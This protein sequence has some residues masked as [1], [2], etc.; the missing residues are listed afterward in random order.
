MV[1]KKKVNS[2]GKLLKKHSAVV[3]VSNRV[4]ALQR[5][6]YSGLLY[7][8]KPLLEQ[9]KNLIYFDADIKVLKTLISDKEINNKELKVA[10]RALMQTIVE[11]NVLKKDKDVWEAS[12]LLSSVKIENGRITYEI[13]A[14]IKQAI[15]EPRMYAVLD[16]TVIKQLTSKH[17]ISLYELAKDYVGA[18]IPSMDIETF[19]KLM[20]IEKDQYINFYDLKRRVID[21]ANAEINEN[22]DID[23]SYK[24]F[25]EG[26]KVTTIKFSV[27]EKSKIV[28][29]SNTEQNS[30]SPKP[31]QVIYKDVEFDHFAAT[32]SIYEKYI[33]KWTARDTKYYQEDQHKFEQISMEAIEAGILS[34]YLRKSD[35]KI[36]SFH[37][38]LGAIIEF[39]ENLP[40]GY[41]HYLRQKYE[42]QKTKTSK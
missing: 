26:K 32:K 17:A 27:K 2:K 18:E 14:R 7:L 13:P 1:M 35:N 15:L 10:L 42:Q 6:A 30:N 40:P 38:C 25:N 37:Y 24:T 34:S 28:S 20:G 19:R 4:T 31:P 41:L 9:N 22:T 36:G 11:F 12:V 5:K 29:P 23:L 33:G 8:A 21:P 3:Q 16:L 39:S